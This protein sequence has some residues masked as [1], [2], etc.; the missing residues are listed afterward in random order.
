M[1]YIGFIW[2]KIFQKFLCYIFGF[3]PNTKIIYFTSFW[4]DGEGTKRPHVY[5][6]DK[7]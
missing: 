7:R 3:P 1:C 6:G 2:N 4:G 5:S